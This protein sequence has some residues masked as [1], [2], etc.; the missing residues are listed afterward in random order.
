MKGCAA[1]V[2]LLLILAPSTFA[3][4]ADP[5]SESGSTAPLDDM[6]W[7]DSTLEGERPRYEERVAHYTRAFHK[8]ELRRESAKEAYRQRTADWNFGQR[9]EIAMV[10]RE[11]RIGE[12][13]ARGMLDWGNR[14]L[15]AKAESDALRAQYNESDLEDPRV[16]ELLWTKHLEWLRLRNASATFG[17]VYQEQV[18][19]H[20][21][22]YEGWDWTALMAALQEDL[23][24]VSSRLYDS[25]VTEVINGCIDDILHRIGTDQVWKNALGW[26]PASAG[27]LAAE[28]VHEV[29]ESLIVNSVVAATEVNFL[30]SVEESGIPRPIGEFWWKEFI[31]AEARKKPG[32]GTAAEKLFSDG[33]IRPTLYKVAERT[34]KGLQKEL[35]RQKVTAERVEWARNT[36]R[37]YVSEGRSKEE[38]ERFI[39][40][41][42]ADAEEHLRPGTKAA[43]D[44]ALKWD[45]V[46]VA[47][48]V[49]EMFFKIG[50]KLATAYYNYSD[51]SLANEVRKY[52]DIVACLS[53]RGEG[54]GVEQYKKVI[55]IYDTW[56]VNCRPEADAERDR[57]LARARE[58]LA[59]VDIGRLPTDLPDRIAGSKQGLADFRAGPLATTEA[60]VR[61][62]ERIW[63]EYCTRDPQIFDQISERMHDIRIAGHDVSDAAKQAAD[64]RK[65]ACEASHVTEAKTASETAA[66]AHV[67]AS[68]A[69]AEIRNLAFDVEQDAATLPDAIELDDLLQSAT[70]LGREADEVATDTHAAHKLRLEYLEKIAEGFHLAKRWSASTTTTELFNP[71]ARELMERF[72]AKRAEIEAIDLGIP[73]EADAQSTAGAALV[74]SILKLDGDQNFAVTCANNLPDVRT[75]VSEIAQIEADAQVQLLSAAAEAEAAADCYGKFESGIEEQA[76][77]AI[78][79]CRFDDAQQAIDRFPSASDE[80]QT[81]SNTLREKRDRDDANRSAVERAWVEFRTNGGPEAALEILDADVERPLCA[82]T[83]QR[84]GDARSDFLTAGFVTESVRTAIGECAFDKARRETTILESGTALHTRLVGEIDDQSQRDDDARAAAEA[85]WNSLATAGVQDAEVVAT[86]KQAKE[87]APCSETQRVI[88]AWI[89]AVEQS[90][91]V[92]AD[93]VRTAIDTCRF[94]VADELLEQ[95]IGREEAPVLRGELADKRSDDDAARGAVSEAEAA[96]VRGDRE[97]ALRI[98]REV[99]GSNACEKTRR[100]AEALIDRITTT[101][102]AGAADICTADI[103]GSEPL[104]NSDRTK[105]RCECTGDRIPQNGECIPRAEAVQRAGDEQMATQ[106]CGIEKRGSRPVWT[107]KKDFHCECASD[108]DDRG[109]RC[110]PRRVAQPP[111]RHP[112]A[113]TPVQPPVYP[114]LG[115]AGDGVAGGATGTSP[116][117]AQLQ[118]QLSQGAADYQQFFSTMQSGQMPS[119]QAHRQMSQMNDMQQ[120]LFAIQRQYDM[121]CRGGQST[122]GGAGTP[123]CARL[124]RE[125]IDR[126]SEHGRLVEESNR[127]RTPQA[128]SAIQP[129]LN[130][131]SARLDAAVAAYKQRCEGGPR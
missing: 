112:P 79:A 84:V 41:V 22:I 108:E 105:F 66:D 56:I 76:N 31:I 119:D 51:F 10:R 2:V 87:N 15:D 82:D 116:R 37:G 48:E 62:V 113:P 1:A 102:D 69:L 124:S 129:R 65:I 30:R 88:Q 38:V 107:S 71:E 64:Q 85:A 45:R 13:A 92:S 110:E 75:F 93:S 24:L 68:E 7:G 131:A 18:L 80:F 17:A 9:E 127:A 90:T 72:D 109:D 96:R 27:S 54:T 3:R 14:F 39:D 111:P 20:L 77:A 97:S 83:E 101:N 100:D 114:P 95:M 19:A 40:G 59:E 34:G 43:I 81:L 99:S 126:S 73:A 32:F 117:C 120:R 91:S 130:A 67:A 52:K 103:A 78:D 23:Y 94:R 12:G 104:W 98:A 53:E 121:E 86:M 49:A 21:D 89:D 35:V 26:S 60:Q 8:L 36:V 6:I 42:T 74:D 125:Q 50:E 4:A 122:L 128:H 5:I 33:E 118:Q 28:C 57:D 47:A 55:R 61:E 58:L 16:R 123:E 70:H 106:L 11:A 29:A 25:M 63:D 46:L 115:G 44:D